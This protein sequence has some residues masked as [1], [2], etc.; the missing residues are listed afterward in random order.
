MWTW[1]RTPVW[2]EALPGHVVA[3]CPGIFSIS[4][5]L[6]PECKMGQS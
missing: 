5:F 6:F 3:M 1:V 4:V 2:V